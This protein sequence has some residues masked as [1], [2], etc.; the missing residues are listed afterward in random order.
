MKLLHLE[1]ETF[2]AIAGASV[3]FGPG[4]TVLHGPNELGK[5]T[6]VEAIR[7]ALLV[8]VTSQEGNSYT[9]WGQ[10]GPAKVTLTFQCD[11]RL[12]R[13]AK[14]FGSGRRATLACSES[15]DAPRFHEVAQGGNVEGRLRD[16]LKWGIPSPGGRGAPAK[17]ASYLLTALLGRQGEAQLIFDASLADDRDNTGKALVTRALGAL[18][19]DALVTAVVERLT[20]RVEQHFT[21]TGRLKTSADSPLVA[22][23]ERV[24]AAERDLAELRKAD[25]EGRLVQQRVVSLQSQ[26]EQAL[27]AVQSAESAVDAARQREQRALRRTQLQEEIGNVAGELAL[28]ERQAGELASVQTELAGKEAQALRLSGDE[29][30]AHAA[31]EVT[32]QELQKAS[33]DLARVTEAV[34]QSAVVAEATRQQRHAQLDSTRTS[35]EARRDAIAAAETAV[36]DLEAL[37]IALESA[38][39]EAASATAQVDAARRVL[40][41]AELEEK[42]GTLLN[43]QESATRLTLAHHDAQRRAHEARARLQQAEADLS[44]A[45]ARLDRAEWAKDA[46]LT[47]A[48]AELA[49][50]RAVE[51][52]IELEVLRREIVALEAAGERATSLRESARSSRAEALRLEEL[53]ANRA[54]P[55]SERITAWRSLEAEIAAAPPP[56]SV[57]AGSIMPL[58]VGLVAT[59]IVA[60]AGAVAL[61]WSP[62]TAAGVALIVG[63]LAA[64]LTWLAV[65]GQAQ[66]AAIE[67][68]RSRL[69]RERWAQEVEPSLRAVGLSSLAT[70]ETARAEL[71]RHRTSAQRLRSEAEQADHDAALE[72][73]AAAPLETRRAALATLEREAPQTD[74][75]AVADRLHQLGGDPSAV[76]GAAEEIQQRL[77]TVHARLRAAADDAVRTLQETRRVRQVE[78]EALVAE[79]AAAQAA[80]DIASK[81]VA[82]D[83]IDTLKSRLA[84]I[85]CSEAPIPSAD[86]AAQL[87]RLR[88]DESAARARA[89]V[90]RSELEAMRPRVHAIASAIG[91][92]LDVARRSVDASLL[93]IATQ[94]SALTTQATSEPLPTPA[95][96][97]IAKSRVAQLEVQVASNR[98]ALEHASAAR[99]ECDE[100]VAALRTDMATRMG[101][102]ASVDRAALEA[103]LQAAREDPVFQDAASEGI[104]TDDALQR[105]EHARQKLDQYT[106]DLNQAKG[107]LHLIAGHVGSER[108][109]RQEEL[110]EYA[111]ADT[112]ERELEEKAAWRLLQ[113]IRTAEA[114][115]TSHLGRSLAGPVLE[116][117]RQLTNGRY[118]S[119]AFDMDL[120]LQGVNAVGAPREIATLS[121]G[122]REQLATLL[123]LAIA[124]HLRTAV[125][126][127]DQL[128]HSDSSRLAWFSE[129]LRTCVREHDHQVIVFTCRPGDYL[130][131]GSG[132]DDV[133]VIDLTAAL[134]R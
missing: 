45:T 125:V 52:H 23:Q 18:D 66:R 17:P 3:A 13:V 128:V 103:R 1:V 121:V 12:W 85:G 134:A 35:L 10:G 117:F 38:N 106:N 104:D 118:D 114:E 46:E 50:L 36:R 91:E 4:L 6:L 43:R 101:A 16:L 102:L 97:E 122:T 90:L 49:L 14:T 94:L 5:S 98:E 113:E 73:R 132:D 75:R 9:P 20:A 92:N 51:T 127:D 96:L 80:R 110:L 120:R 67:S 133:A 72:E 79:A 84:A 63:L 28:L 86:A 61:G 74:P 116:T 40:E 124:G 111:R 89:E 42:F 88:Q 57:A 65:R 131:G 2:R 19:K 56:P 105:L 44:D 53:A 109:A 25:G 47:A 71:D 95:E 83:E 107:Q 70:Y 68:E 58:V 93:D 108:L 37:E 8:S 24:K 100:A 27:A 33:E 54:L 78:Y 11:G 30:D 112:L 126:L 29:R 26:R 60:L 99:V 64:G 34:S 77:E 39:A 123:R 31:L 7:A 59:V 69:N 115:R 55:T 129:R 21:T 41:R 119:I 15:I 62:T 82:A 130:R 32:R 48:E 76:R 81:H 87:E 22:L